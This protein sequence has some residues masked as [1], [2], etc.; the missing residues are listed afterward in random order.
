MVRARLRW[1]RPGQTYARID[2]P[3]D[4]AAFFRYRV[5]PHRPLPQE[6]FKTL[7]SMIT[8]P[9]DITSQITWRF[10]RP[11]RSP[12]GDEMNKLNIVDSYNAY[13]SRLAPNN[14]QQA[15]EAAIGG[16]FKAFGIVE[17]EM[18]RFYGLRPDSELIDVG[19]G[20]GRLTLALFE[21][22]TV[23]EY[24]G[25]DVVPALIEHAK[26]HARP[27][28]KFHLVT[29]L[30]IPAADAVADF[31]CLFSVLTHLLHEQTYVYLQE[32]RRVLRPGGRIVF[33]FLEFTEPSHWKVFESTVADAIDIGGHP[34][35]VF[36]PREAITIWAQ[37]LDLTVVDIR[38]G[39]DAF[40]PLPHP[41]VLDDGR[42]LESK[43]N[44]GQSIC[45]LE[46]PV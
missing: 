41:V 31:V 14:Q 44:L 34:L 26:T 24:I 43:G 46:R 23:G 9:A 20:S 42:V 17:R 5:R 40:V 13:V 32:C 1:S 16:E 38:S 27:S 3:I 29:S 19:C 25:T 6:D 2:R 35:N 39:A 28:W 18:L 11:V 22:L 10:S 30:T 37:H 7:A 4:K 15:L 33:S 21:Y 8:T 36:I 45:V 12:I